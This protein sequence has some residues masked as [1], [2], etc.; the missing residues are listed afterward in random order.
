M[1]K[2][3]LLKVGKMQSDAGATVDNEQIEEVE[4]FK[5]LGSPKAADGNCSKATR[6]RIGM[7]KKKMLDLVPIWKDRRINKDLKIKL[8]CSQAWAV[9]TYGAEGW[10]LKKADEKRIE[11]AELGIY[12]RMLRVCWTEH[13]TDESILTELNTT[14]QL[15]GFVVRRK[16]SYFGHTIRDI[17]C[18]LVKCVIQGKVS[19]KRKR[20]RRKT[21]YSSNITQW[22]SES[23]ERIKRDTRD[24]AE[25]R[26]LVRCA[27]R[28][29][30]YHS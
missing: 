2:S 20:G 27:A 17:G 21:S 9:F 3:T 25:W 14:I 5:Y 28:A 24:R 12:R 11:L 16:L 18:E 30:D 6:S 15:L 8:V 1:K 19:G 26:R 4:H 29:A 23:M 22:M 10:T 13:R 7:A